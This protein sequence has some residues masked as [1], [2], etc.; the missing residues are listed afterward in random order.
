MGVVRSAGA[1]VLSGLFM[2]ATLTACANQQ[3][4]NTLN[5]GDTIGPRA[6]FEG[7]PVRR[8][9]AGDYLAGHLA[10]GAGDWGVA[11][12]FMN[13]ALERDEDNGQLLRRAYLLNIGSGNYE[14]A[15]E[16]AREIAAH[17]EPLDLAL[18]L[19]MAEAARNNDF[20]RFDALLD[21][22]SDDGLQTVLKP[23]FRTWELAARGETEA[24][25]T[26]LEKF[27]SFGGFEPLIA[28]HSAYILE[29]AG[30]IEVARA[31][32]LE[33]MTLSSTLRAGQ[34]YGA[35]L[36]RQG[37]TEAALE[38]YSRYNGRDG[39]TL[40]ASG[41]RNLADG[42][43]PDGG[44]ENFS[45]GIGAMLFD[46]ASVLQV[47]LGLELT[48]VLAQIANYADQDFSLAQLLLADLLSQ[49]KQYAAAEAVY[50]K[51]IDDSNIALAAR[52]RLSRMYEDADRHDDAL[53]VVRQAARIYPNEYAL[54]SRL[55]D[56]YRQEEQ[57]Y[58]A[59]SAYDRAIDLLPRI[60]PNNWVLFYTRG[61]A[62]ERSGQWA[63]A[64]ADLKRALE[65]QPSQPFVLNYLGYSWAD[66]GLHL[67]QAEN[68]IR[69]A[70]ILRPNDGFIVDSLGWVLYRLGRFE[71]ATPILERAVALSPGDQTINDH[72]GDALWRVGRRI[73]AR[74]QWQRAIDLGDDDA[75]T[76]AARHKL[77][78]GLPPAEST[79][80]PPSDDK[81][82]SA[83]IASD[84]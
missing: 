19:L 42:G 37:E 49:R 45:D 32:Y 41:I 4:G 78:N 79:V 35:F 46:F 55:G 80:E 57:F 50:D 14:T 6:E 56:L 24:A 26:E 74:F 31:A 60:E 68:M 16:Q 5:V 30:D 21:R 43:E 7:A 84:G 48:L 9:A 63:E 82:A 73:E 28:L 22:L 12:V 23:G 51:I 27:Q 20:D 81:A 69:E 67:Q 40:L 54:Y 36:A 29:Y 61:I 70:V 13:D 17:D 62:H 44:V 33:A 75:V 25:L 38:V 53:S 8:T 83:A 52:I 18:V 64:E 77:E 65:L 15:L 58:Q 39:S 66:Q 72:L 59:I 76:E 11:A 47:D 1:S 2:L 71:E 3:P 10:Q 34:A